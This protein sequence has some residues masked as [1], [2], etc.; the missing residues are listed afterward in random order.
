MKV[1]MSSI[2]LVLALLMIVVSY[3]VFIMSPNDVSALLLRKRSESNHYG[4]KTMYSK[5]ATGLTPE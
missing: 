2:S 3:Y 1:K 4:P 5:C